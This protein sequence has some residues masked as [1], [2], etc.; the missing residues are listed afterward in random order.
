MSLGF[1]ASE[2]ACILAI[3]KIDYAVDSFLGCFRFAKNCHQAR[4]LSLYNNKIPNY[5]AM[6]AESSERLLHIH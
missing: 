2:L 6:T 3:F 1:G 4:N 5:T